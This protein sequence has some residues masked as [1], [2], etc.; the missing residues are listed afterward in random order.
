METENRNKKG[1]KQMQT[2]KNILSNPL[3]WVAILFITSQLI[4]LIIS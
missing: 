4:N 2:I 3:N 1:I